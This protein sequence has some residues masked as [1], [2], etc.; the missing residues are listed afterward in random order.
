MNIIISLL[1]VST[2]SVETAPILIVVASPNAFIVL[3]FAFSK[4]NVSVTLVV[5]S[6]PSTF[7]SKSMS[8]LCL[9]VVVPMPTA[10][11]VNCVVPPNAF[12]I[13]ALSSNKLNVVEVVVK[14]PPF[15]A[16]SAS[17]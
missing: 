12:T 13:L 1:N 11:I 8:T 4:L 16:K 3:A 7:K 14:S 17:I 2:L 5:I 15:T 9:I 10:P 6:P